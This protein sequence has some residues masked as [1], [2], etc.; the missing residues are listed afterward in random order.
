MDTKRCSYCHKMARAEAETCSR[1]GH[2]YVKSTNGVK[3]VNRVPMKSSNPASRGSRRNETVHLSMS[4]GNTRIQRQSIPPASP[5][6]AGHYSGLHPEDQPYQS[7]VMAVQRPPVRQSNLRGAVQTER[8][9]V[10]LPRPDSIVEPEPDQ[11]AIVPLLP[12]RFSFP[13]R[14]PLP[15]KSWPRGR[16]VPVML[17]LSCLIFLVASS[18]LAYIFI[19]K[20]PLPDK[21]VLSVMPDQL[22]VND[23]FT[24]SGKGFGTNDPI[25]FTHDQDNAPLLD[26][27][28]KPLQTHADDL[29]TFSV[30][31]VVPTNWEVGQ[32]SI[33]A[34]D[35]GKEQS[36]SV[37]AT[38]TVQQSSLAP[39]LLQLSNASVDLGTNVPGVV[40]K[41]IITLINA[42]GRHLT[43]Q[44]SS[45]QPWL[46]VP[47]NNGTFSGRSIVQVMTDSGTL[48]PQ[49]YAGHITFR[50]QGSSDK[51][52]TLSVTMTV[53]SAPPASLVVSS[54]S[55]MYSG[56]PTQNPPDQTITLQNNGG[57]PLA[58]SSEI[59]NSASWLS[60]IPGSDH[61][62]A[63]AS[64][65]VTVSVQSQQLALGSYQGTITFKGGTNPQVSVSLNVLAPGN[66]IL[67]P[68][69]LNF[70][71]TGH[72]PA[73]QTISLQ[74][75]G[76][77][78]LAWTLAATTFDGA[79][80][81]NATPS[82]GDLQPGQ[83]MNV[84]VSV[85][86]AIL[87]PRSYQGALSFSYGGLTSQVAVSLTVSIPPSAAISLNQSAL[88]F[89]TLQGT[90]PAPQSF[91]ITNTGN[92]TLNWVITEDQN[93]IVIAP[94][95]SRSGSLAP[96]KTAVITVTPNVLQANAGTLAAAITVADSDGGTKVLSQRITVNI[97]VKGHASITL[98][99]SGMVFTHDSLVTS[100]YQFLVIANSGSQT[101]N[102]V[103]KSSAP[104]LSTSTGSGALNPGA[105]T[106]INIS[107]DSSTLAPGSYSASFVVSDNDASTTAAPQ[108]LIVNLVVT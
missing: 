60:I 101:L 3:K 20:K 48:R 69:S 38:L 66:L 62:A 107:C 16:F 94:T 13:P 19:S 21:Q 86:A 73:S 1:C 58:W 47:P 29:G 92:T 61:I 79:N 67:S 104:W 68:S 80:W 56:T 88:N 53:K 50:Q 12:P 7:A 87:K 15:K 105:N 85:N 70:S 55:L 5:H 93:G 103:A 106:L 22:R 34:I 36:I 11:Q 74:N 43:W 49:S 25:S 33:Y 51:P 90:N 84:T 8:E 40:A 65:T 18:L 30:Q 99:T 31:V 89:T 72:N 52:L 26:G 57:Q 35:I 96:N 46:T 17:T 91:T 64:E 81:L 4:D 28:G 95:S 59:G 78:P 108:T 77:G 98:S 71:S 42:G 45:D 41:K 54:A 39:P 44:A 6:R 76:G 32:H 75:S 102:W 2:P 9:R 37:V 100:S 27:N 83:A 97:V 14:S 10:I 82:S 24:L 63:H 23:A